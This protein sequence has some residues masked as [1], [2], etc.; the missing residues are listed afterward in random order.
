MGNHWQDSLAL[1]MSGWLGSPQLLG[2][3][4]PFQMAEIHGF[5]YRVILTT[6]LN[7]MIL[8][9]GGGNSNILF[10]FHPENPGKMNSF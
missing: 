10:N 1:S 5:F 6:Y 9:V 3:W 4:D 7:G 8:Q 2:L